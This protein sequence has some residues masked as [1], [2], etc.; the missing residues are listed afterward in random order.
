MPWSPV[1]VAPGAT[2]DA[3]PAARAAARAGS[4]ADGI[5]PRP[6]AG[7][8]A[9][10]NPAITPAG[11]PRRASTDATPDS[12]AGRGRVG[13]PAPAPAALTPPSPTA[14]RRDAASR[15]AQAR[16]A[17][18][19]SPTSPSAVID[20]RSGTGAVAAAAAATAAATALSP[21]SPHGGRRSA[22]PPGPLQ[23]ACIGQ[24]VALAPGKPA[25]EPRVQDGGPG[26]FGSDLGGGGA[27]PV[28]SCWRLFVPMQ[29]A[30]PAAMVS[31]NGPLPTAAQRRLLLDAAAATAT[32]WPSA[33]TVHEPKVA[34]GIGGGGEDGGSSSDSGFFSSKSGEG[35]GNYD[36]DSRCR[37]DRQ[38]EHGQPLC[39]AGPQHVREISEISEVS[40]LSS[41]VFE[42]SECGTMSRGG[43]AA[44]RTPSRSPGLPSPSESPR[45]PRLP[46]FMT[47]AAAAHA[48]ANADALGGGRPLP[49]GRRAGGPSS[50]LAAFSPT[51]LAGGGE[52]RG[53]NTGGGGGGEGGNLSPSRWTAA[54]VRWRAAVPSDPG[55]P[56]PAA[57]AGVP[58]HRQHLV[59]RVV[60]P[61]TGPPPPV[62]VVA[63]A[64]PPSPAAG[65]GPLGPAARF[66]RGPTRERV[67]SC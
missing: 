55:A 52:R 39:E 19:R 42:P 2:T 37:T 29:D 49:G 28:V 54:A 63:A 56:A 20:H 36:S 17:G 12:P 62:V 16:S 14:V 13:I 11:I 47:A 22:S 7:I 1:P 60:A 67:A 41:D 9:A 59:Q 44:P 25:A 51:R 48:S 33:A 10:G 43:S 5:D 40:E 35:R 18:P 38:G 26:A 46:P 31:V 64:A 50:G 32:Q 45:L 58:A 3:T 15:L 6:A 61:G 57:E 27:G 66:S 53:G 30:L 4:I 8:S 65:R 24:R 34:F 21:V 23:M